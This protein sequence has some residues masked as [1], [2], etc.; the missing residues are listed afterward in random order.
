VTVAAGPR[1]AAGAG[2]AGGGSSG[3]PAAPGG[4]RAPGRG[5]RGQ[6]RGRGRRRVRAVAVTAAVVMAGAGAAVA[7]QALRGGGPP[8]AWLT[9]F[10]GYGSTSVA[11]AG[12]AV[13]VSVAPER[14]ATASTSHAALVVTARTYGDIALTLRLRTEQQLRTGQAGHPKAWEVAWVLWHYTSDDRFYA[15]TLEP[16]GWELSKQDPA[17]PG[18]ERFLASG[19]VPRFPAGASY[20]VGVV[21]VG[22]QITVSA[23]GR[24]L[25][26]YTDRSD[27]YLGGAVGL[28]AEDAQATFD[29]IAIASL[30]TG[31]K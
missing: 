4:S 18:G 20:A 11:G 15:L 17:Y 13:A 10:N 16:T 19:L 6:G 28:Y 26:R 1:P 2:V 23:D 21:Q 5:R 25:A 12:A 3:P 27:P 29:H 31:G 14:A 22:N 30:S 8:P 24:L 9:A 7:S